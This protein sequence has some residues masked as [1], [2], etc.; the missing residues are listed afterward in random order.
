MKFALNKDVDNVVREPFE[1]HYIADG[2]FMLV[3]RNKN[4]VVEIATL[5]IN[6]WRLIWQML[7]Q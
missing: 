6:Q 3:I 4:K 1:L 2:Y 5:T 7:T